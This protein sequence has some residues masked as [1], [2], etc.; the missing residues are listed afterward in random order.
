LIVGFAIALLLG[1]VA[2]PP[3][4][5]AIERDGGQ[6]A[7]R[8][9]SAGLAEATTVL[10]SATERRDATLFPAL[11]DSEA[12]ARLPRVIHGGGQPLPLW[13]RKLTAILPQTTAAML[14]LDYLHRSHSP[15]PARL[16]GLLR[17]MAAHTNQC[18]CSEALAEA[19]LRAAGVDEG[20][21]R[22]LA[23]DLE[24]FPEAERAALRFARKLTRAG[25][26]VTDEE[27]TH[28]VHLYGE[29]QVVALVLLLAH[30]NF[31]DRLLH[32]LDL[33]PEVGEPLKP[34]EVQFAE[35]PLGFSAARHKAQVPWR[36]TRTTASLRVFDRESLAPAA[37]GVEQALKDQQGRQPRIALPGDQ[38]GQVR[39]GLVC[40]T[41]QPELAAAWS[42]CTHAF[43]VEAEQDPVLE[44][45]VFWLITHK[46]HCFY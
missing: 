33:A 17:W 6:G 43:A 10:L 4:Q 7:P 5:P 36:S 27:V 31:Q 21:L 22:D 45:S 2:A 34:L 28:L 11:S 3:V 20:A 14:E 26:T 40:R 37:G 13:A 12:W 24:S 16:R 41:Y 9:V 29:K 38:P 42:A 1:S 30:A 8:P 44:Q 18:P 23:A 15:L 19:D 46:L 25:Y 39:W 32:A 35:R